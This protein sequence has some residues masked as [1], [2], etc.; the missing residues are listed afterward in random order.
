[1]TLFFLIDLDPDS[2]S[3]YGSTKLP[4]TDPIWIPGPQHW[5]VSL[6]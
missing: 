5:W 1:M 6:N 2:F 4:N 3:E